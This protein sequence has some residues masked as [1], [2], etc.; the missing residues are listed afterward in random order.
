MH[1]ISLHCIYM[2]KT[3]FIYFTINPTDWTRCA[4]QRTMKR[5][6]TDERKNKRNRE[7]GEKNPFF[8]C[9]F[10][11][12]NVWAETNC[13]G[14]FN[15]ERLP[16]D[17]LSTVHR[18]YVTVI[19]RLFL[20]QPI[21]IWFTWIRVFSKSNWS[22]NIFFV[23]LN[24]E[25]TRYR[26]TVKCDLENA[27]KQS[28]PH[29]ICI[30]VHNCVFDMMAHHIYTQI[31]YRDILVWRDQSSFVFCFCRLALFSR[32]LVEFWQFGKMTIT[33]FS[34][35]PKLSSF[36][37]RNMWSTLR[38]CQKFVRKLLWLQHSMP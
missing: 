36:N 5:M 31:G 1:L 10:C 28:R 38:Y 22:V 19:F 25:N 23:N 24:G 30:C 29:Q 34:S 18:L 26:S 37:V 7:I 27:R 33:V 13:T 3:Q 9:L 32:V 17:V 15:V 2:C 11:M 16:T 6:I 35:W 14:K 20:T 12:A 4:I 8:C 21:A